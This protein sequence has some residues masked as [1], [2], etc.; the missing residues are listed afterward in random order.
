[1]NNAEIAQMLHEFADLMDLQGDVFKRNAYRRAARSVESLEQDIQ[2]VIEEGSLDKVPG[3]GK[4]IAVK[5]MEMMETGTSKELERLRGSF[6][7]GLAEVMR[8]PEVGPRTAARLYRELGVSDL[9]GLKEA[10]TEHRIRQLPGFGER[11]EM[12]ILRGID[13][14]EKQGSRMLL[15]VALLKGE[16][17][18]EHIRSSGFPLASVAGSMRRMKET[19]G[20]VDILVGTD[21]P[22]EAMEA[23]ASF[24]EVV[25]TIVRGDRKTSVRLA[26]GIQADMRAVPE[27]SYG[28]ALQYFTGSKEHNVKL[29]RIAIRKGLRLNEYGLF[30]AAGANLVAGRPEEDI[31]RRLGLQPMPPELREDRGEIEAAAEGRLPRLVELGDVRG[32]LH[33]HTVLSDGHGTMREMAVAAMRRGYEYIGLTDH[34][35]SLHIAH[36]LDDDELLASVE[37]ARQLTEELNFPVLRGGEID[38]L[39]DGSLDYPRE[40]LEQ[41]DYVIASV[42]SRFKM[43]ADEMTDRVIRAIRSGRV[44]ILGHPTGRLLGRREPYPIDMEAVMDEARKHRVAMEVNG[45][46]D[47]LDL[48]DVN[49]RKAKEKGVMIVLNTDSHRESNLANMRLAVGTARRGWLEPENVLNCL[50][51]RQLKEALAR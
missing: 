20:D 4:G 3:V 16:A 18:V 46:P 17:L 8:V 38:V 2:Q 13:L 6:P 44:H 51:Y 35:A 50:P 34:S 10:A 39:E 49:C 11:S 9:A 14:V 29:R 42:H 19:V 36:G 7:P 28:A 48:N 47:R 1:V 37:Q 32:D 21:R 33:V 22:R 15:S 27:A 40:V 24:P 30:D 43:T 26:D 12:N 23:F 5:I 31:Y 41:L 25:G 45:Y